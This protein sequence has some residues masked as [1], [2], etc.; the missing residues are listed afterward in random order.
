MLRSRFTLNN[1]GTAS[2]KSTE[3]VDRTKDKTVPLLLLLL[4]IN[5]IITGP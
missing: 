2:H 1:L 4:K 3:P 5:G